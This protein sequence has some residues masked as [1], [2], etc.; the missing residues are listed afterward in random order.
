MKQIDKVH[1]GS[2]VAETKG[3]TIHS[4]ARFYDKLVGIV[5][6]GRERQMRMATLELIN[7]QPESTVLDVGCGTGS[8]AIEAKRLALDGTVVGIDSS[9]NM[10]NIAKRKAEKARVDVDFRVGV[11]EQI[12][13]SGNYFDIVL[14][15]LMM[16]HL[17]DDLKKEGL[18]EVQRI[19]K[20]GGIFLIVDLDLSAFSLASFIHGHT[21]PNEHSPELAEISQYMEEAGYVSIETGK[22]KF[23]GFS[24]N[25][26]KKADL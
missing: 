16:H 15:S 3:R 14:S 1:E 5:C 18:K 19:L 10:V 20:P 6:L 26:E 24:F 13:F 11:I 25:K 2:Y 23:R 22:L 12:E 17:P 8:L 4:W 9:S 7:I 21:S